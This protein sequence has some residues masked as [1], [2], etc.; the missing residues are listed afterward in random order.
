M[1]EGWYIGFAFLAMSM[2]MGG[3]I[4]I[5]QRDRHRKREQRRRDRGE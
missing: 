2:C 1:I 4:Y 5:I 3:I